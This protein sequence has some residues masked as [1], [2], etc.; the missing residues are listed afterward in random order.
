MKT[1]CKIQESTWT[2]FDW[3]FQQWK[4]CSKQHQQWSTPALQTSTKSLHIS[5]ISL[6][7]TSQPTSIFDRKTPDPTLILLLWKT[8][9]ATFCAGEFHEWSR[10]A[11]VHGLKIRSHHDTE[12]R[13]NTY[14]SLLV[15]PFLCSKQKSLEWRFESPPFGFFSC[16]HGRRRLLSRK[17]VRH[18]RHTVPC[19]TIHS[20]LVHTV[21]PKS[22]AKRVFN[23]SI[24]SNFFFLSTGEKSHNTP[25]M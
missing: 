25:R 22:C 16:S 15:I 13:E 17:K 24:H 20:L 23:G 14:L 3:C 18:Q 1:I 2:V 9:C 21:R 10:F 12:L 6:S 11:S 8:F 7:L 19:T 4:Y 5:S